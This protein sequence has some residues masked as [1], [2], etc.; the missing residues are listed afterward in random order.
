M[1]LGK[2]I[3]SIRIQLGLDQEELA[4]RANISVSYLSYIEMN[5]RNP[6]FSTIKDIATALNIPLSILVF[7]SAE[8][9]ELDNLG[10]ALVEKL[11]YRLFKIIYENNRSTVGHGKK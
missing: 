5:N 9:S 10:E 6:S 11:S 8:S 4:L 1:N 2:A 3:K 7:L